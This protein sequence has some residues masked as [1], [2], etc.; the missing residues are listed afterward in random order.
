METF[1]KTEKEPTVEQST[2]EEI[3]QGWIKEVILVTDAGN[4][5]AVD[6]KP[7]T[8]DEFMLTKPA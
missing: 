2:V 4:H 7:E 1:R 5:T 6:R 8:Q 3:V